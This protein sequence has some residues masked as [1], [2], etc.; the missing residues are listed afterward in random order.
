MMTD[1]IADMFTRIRNALQAKHPRVDVPKSKIKVRIA[2]ILKEEGFIRNFRTVEQGAQ[3]ILRMQLKYQDGEGAIHGIRRI[4]KPGLR[5]YV[6]TDEVPRVLNGL[7][8]AILST[9]QGLATD[10]ACRE[11]RVGGEVLGYVW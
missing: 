7:G 10:V 11:K 4:S 2:E 6:S 9:S 8:T 5:V 1:P 3:G